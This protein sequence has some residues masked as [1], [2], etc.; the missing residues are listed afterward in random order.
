MEAQGLAKRFFRTTSLIA[1]LAQR[2]RDPAASPEFTIAALDGAK[3][4]A[5]KDIPDLDELGG[6]YQRGDRNEHG[7]TDGPFA[8]Y[9]CT[10]NGGT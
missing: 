4:A 10:W 9:T 6:I 7:A 3:A 5:L 8:A 2:L 1:P